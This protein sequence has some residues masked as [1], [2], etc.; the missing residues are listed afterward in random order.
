MSLSCAYGSL[1]LRSAA[2]VGF[3]SALSDIA[4]TPA[5]WKSSFGRKSSE[6]SRVGQAAAAFPANRRPSSPKETV[7]LDSASDEGLH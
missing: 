6:R 2:A 3:A 5:S 7:S 4:P 1:C